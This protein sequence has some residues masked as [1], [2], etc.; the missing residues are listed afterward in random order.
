MYICKNCKTEMTCLKNG[1]GARWHEAHYYAG[2][3]YKCKRC[4]TEIIATDST[5]IQSTDDPGIDMTSPIAY[6]EPEES[7]YNLGE[8][9]YI[10]VGAYGIDDIEIT[11]SMPINV[12]LAN[13]RSY[14]NLQTA[15]EKENR[16]WILQEELQELVNE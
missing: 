8:K 7:V 1:F 14:P 2:D 11:E 4:G 6:H 12:K 13:G 5:P 3:L 15:Y 10:R 16:I 9:I